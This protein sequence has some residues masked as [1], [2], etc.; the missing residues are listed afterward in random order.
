MPVSLAASLRAGLARR[1]RPIAREPDS[2]VGFVGLLCAGACCSA[3]AALVRLDGT[4]R[5]WAVLGLF[6]LLAL[7]FAEAARHLEPLRSSVRTDLGQEPSAVWS[8]AAAIALTPGQAVLLHAGVFGHLW[9]RL[10]R[11]AGEL[12]YR[13][14]C[15][16]CGAL[17]GC[18]G[19]NLL[20]HLIEPA[21]SGAPARLADLLAV[22]VAMAGYACVT[23]AL[24]AVAGLTVGGRAGD[25]MGP[26]AEPVSDFAQLCAGGLVAALA[27]I[28]PWLCVLV[29]APMAA[30]QRGGISRELEAAAMFDG[31]TGLLNAHAWERLARRELVRG[32]RA[33]HPLAVLLVDIDRFKLVN[34]RF[35]HLAGDAALRDVASALTS[36]V[37]A[38]DAVGR[39]G[40]EEFVVVLPKAGSREALRIA[41]RLRTRIND[42]HVT[43]AGI[44]AQD[45]RLSASIGVA[46]AP[47]DGEE[48]ADLMLA[49][50]AALYRAKELGRN[51]VQLAGRGS[52]AAGQSLSG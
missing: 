5:Q 21:W 9:L 49:A 51:R 52:G 47:L 44:S 10:Q 36:G 50:D 33:N 40:G 27:G 26:V 20:V 11:P 16:G 29:L 42:V 46:C 18:L 3:V 45:V 38:A 6:G 30:L 28:N 12:G 41:E 14:M 4:G 34:D 39:F 43:A 25:L 13:M 48:L 35:G 17:L 1:G 8:L 24:R 2:V 31:K 37:R 32:H 19:A 15:R 23:H 7:T 22:L